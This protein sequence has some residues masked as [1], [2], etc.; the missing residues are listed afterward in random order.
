MGPAADGNDIF[1]SYVD[2]CSATPTRVTDVSTA[3][4]KSTSKKRGYNA[5]Y[6]R[7]KQPKRVRIQM[8]DK[9]KGEIIIGGKRTKSPKP[10]KL[11][12]TRSSKCAT[13]QKLPNVGRYNRVSVRKVQND[14]QAQ[15]MKQD[16]KAHGDILGKRNKSVHRVGPSDSILRWHAQP[17]IDWS[18]DVSENIK[19]KEEWWEEETKLFCKR[20]NSFIACM[21]QVQGGKWIF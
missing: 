12:E 21:N 18:K 2:D 3:P 16:Q 4:D 6:L 19:D 13:A 7:H 1:C 10:V 14:T 8:E 5:I 11:K 17:Q 9:S 15:S 20:A